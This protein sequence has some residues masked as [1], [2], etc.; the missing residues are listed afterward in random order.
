M[1]K[2]IVLLQSKVMQI[3][4]LCSRAGGPRDGVGT[5]I[6]NGHFESNFPMPSFG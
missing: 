4:I 1:A 3:S 6:R 5:L 2:R